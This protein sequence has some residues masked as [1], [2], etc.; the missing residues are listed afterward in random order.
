M[1]CRTEEQSLK[2]ILDYST[3]I[4]LLVLVRKK[5]LSIK[6]EPWWSGSAVV[7]V[8]RNT[9]GP[10]ETRRSSLSSSFSLL[11]SLLYNSSQSPIIQAPTFLV[12]QYISCFMCLC[13]CGIWVTAWSHAFLLTTL[14]PSCS[15]LTPP[16]PYHFSPSYSF[17]TWSLIGCFLWDHHSWGWKSSGCSRILSILKQNCK[18]YDKG[19]LAF[20][21]EVKGFLN[22]F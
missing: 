13:P 3:F 2:K 7:D 15:P 8:E 5:R 22:C 20:I 18:Q 1:M 10:R 12:Y 19:V 14:S 4:H 17:P 6:C 11:L 21:L 16:I 9:E